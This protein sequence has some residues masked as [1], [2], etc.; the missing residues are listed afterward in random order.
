M[1]TRKFKFYSTAQFIEYIEKIKINRNVTH[2]QVHHTWKPTLKGYNLSKDKEQVIRSMWVYHTKVNKWKD[3]GQHFT[4]VP[5][6]AWNGRS[7]ES[8]P[9]GIANHNSGGVMF[10]II[11]DFDIGREEL[12]GSYLHNVSVMLAATSKALNLPIIFH[13]EYSDKTCPGT[14]I[15]KKDFLESVEHSMKTLEQEKTGLCFEGN[16]SHLVYYNI[17]KQQEIWA[18]LYKMK[19]SVSS[20]MIRSLMQNYLNEVSKSNLTIGARLKEDSSHKSMIRQLGVLGVVTSPDYWSA[21]PAYVP[22]SIVESLIANM[23]REF[24]N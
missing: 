3:I 20:N 24:T 8:I 11:G 21:I 2:I 4:L 10:E 1:E 18:K 14:S 9:A 5:G 15:I 17:V 19:S 12:S 22:W 16:L 13:N 6:G 7:L 23:V